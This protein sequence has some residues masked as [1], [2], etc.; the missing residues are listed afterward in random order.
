MAR[1]VVRR[2]VVVR[3]KYYWPNF[4]LAFWTIIMLATAGVILGIFAEFIRIQNQLGVGIPWLFPFGV[5]VGAL[6]YVFLILE[7]LL[8]IGRRLVPGIM[9]LGSIILLVL[10][11][12]GAIDTGIQLFGNDANVSGNCDRF[13]DNDEQR[14]ISVNTLA[15][16][17]QD[18]ICSSWDAAFAFWI[19]GSVFFVYM[20]I[21]ASMVNRNQYMYS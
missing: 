20:I 21:M 18:S 16:L 11:I 17:E 1:S 8:I 19:I 4:Q 3:Q 2:A 5:T 7:I 13:V 15:W 9:I 14:G 12:T 6:L 10:F